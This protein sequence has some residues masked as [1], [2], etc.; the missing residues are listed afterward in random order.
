MKALFIGGTG[1]ISS[2]VSKLA[3]ERGFD[4]YLLNR[5][6]RAES[7][8]EGARQIIADRA[9]QEATRRA[10]AGQDFDV[11][12]NWI[13]FTPEQAAS[14]LELFRGRTAQYIFISSAS[15]YEKPC[16]SFPITESTPLR[17]P[18]W[19]YSRDKIACEEFLNEAS[20]DSGFPVTIV[21]P[22]L[23]Y[24][25]A[26]IP[27]S[28]SSWNYPWTLV[29]RMRRGKPIIVHGD[30]TT[31]WTLTHNSDFAKGFLGLMGSAAAIGQAFHITSDEILTWDKI[32]LEIGK[33]AGVE[34]KI[35]HIS[36][37]FIESFA[38]ELRGSLTGD[39]S[40]CGIF[41]NSKIRRFVPGYEAGVAFAQGIE[42][43][44]RW[45]EARPER[46]TIDEA[47][48]ALAERILLAHEAAKGEPRT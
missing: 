17:N 14:D 43:S 42:A 48:N 25:P 8:P 11:I 13:A 29:D 26:M 15:A 22:S 1:L 45:F 12:V 7:F 47:F 3:V 37:E 2:A 23:T 30:G 16:A 32:A 40:Q 27:F 38:P 36:S 28:V 39:K 5:G 33:A 35:T 6:R 34:P 21:R 46:Q 41:D 10:L 9:E 31:P 44:L 20:L 18:Y 4:L 24:G 19:R